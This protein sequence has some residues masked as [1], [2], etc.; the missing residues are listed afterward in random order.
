MEMMSESPTE[1]TI[2][3]ETLKKNWLKGGVDEIKNLSERGL[4]EAWSEAAKEQ[5]SDSPWR[6]RGPRPKPRK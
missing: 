5:P 1:K 4:E 6:R 2:E 3:L